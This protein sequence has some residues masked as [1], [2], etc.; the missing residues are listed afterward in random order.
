M[1]HCYLAARGG[2]VRDQRRGAV[3]PGKP[4]FSALASI[5]AAQR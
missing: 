4:I 5:P 3:I 1:D 2:R